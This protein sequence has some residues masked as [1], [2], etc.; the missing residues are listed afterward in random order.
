MSAAGDDFVWM[1]ECACV[2]ESEYEI[3]VCSSVC[4]CV[5]ERKRL[6]RWEG[7]FSTKLWFIT[8]LIILTTSKQ[9]MIN[10][11]KTN[12]NKNVS[13]TDEI[14]GEGWVCERILW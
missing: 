5:G 11:E 8:L 14:C 12:E 3:D 6:G 2:R 10:G 13:L 1:F 7:N 9:K 4:E